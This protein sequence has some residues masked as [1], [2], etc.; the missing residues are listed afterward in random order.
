VIFFI[1][2]AKRGGMLARLA[3]YYTGRAGVVFR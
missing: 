3:Y 2:N 1:I